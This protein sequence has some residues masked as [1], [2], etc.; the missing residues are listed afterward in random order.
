MV[1]AKVSPARRHG[2]E[3]ASAEGREI[4]ED[5]MLCYGVPIEIIE[6]VT[7]QVNGQNHISRA[8]Q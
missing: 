1:P 7:R 8:S 4:G 6:R 3:L 2:V 5:F